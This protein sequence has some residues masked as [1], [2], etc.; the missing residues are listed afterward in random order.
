MCLFR[1]HDI[2]LFTRNQRNRGFLSTVCVHLSSISPSLVGKI[3]LCP[4]FETLKNQYCGC[5]YIDVFVLLSSGSFFFEIHPTPFLRHRSLADGGQAGTETVLARIKAAKK[6]P[7]VT[8]IM[9]PGEGGSARSAAVVAAG[10]ATVEK[11]LYEGMKTVR[12]VFFNYVE[13]EEAE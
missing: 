2:Y 7:G 9:L 3:F 6:L 13:S 8:E 1:D 12:F 11:N 10:V 4:H 5:T